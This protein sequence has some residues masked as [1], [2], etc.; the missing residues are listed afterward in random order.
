M[1]NLLRVSKKSLLQISK[2]R[3][4]WA[5]LQFMARASQHGLIVS[6]PW[7]DSARYDFIVDS[8]GLVRRVQVK[9]T[10]RR[11]NNSRAYLCNIVCGLGRQRPYRID[12]IDFFALLVIPEDVWY[13]VPI[14]DI[15]R[16]RW[17]VFL[18][19]ADPRNLYAPYLEAWH[20]LRRA[21]VR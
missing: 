3:G 6:K 10:Y 7:G 9:S 1:K 16:A 17:A 15:R 13:I 4:E 21:P 5:E 20:L 12:E 18:N 19:P 14:E 11:V 2:Q 8:R